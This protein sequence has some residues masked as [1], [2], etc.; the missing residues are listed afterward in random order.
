MVSTVFRENYMGPGGLPASTP[1]GGAVRVDASGSFSLQR[2]SFFG[3]YIWGPVALLGPAT[4]G[5]GAVAVSSTNTTI[6]SCTFVGN[7]VSTGGGGEG[8]ALHVGS[9]ASAM[10]VTVIGSAFHRNNALGTRTGAGGAIFVGAERVALTMTSCVVATSYV[11][12][13]QATTGTGLVWGRGAGLAVSNGRQL[14]LTN[15][16]FASNSI[17]VRSVKAGSGQGHGAGIWVGAVQRGAAFTS[18]TIR[19]N[20][21]SAYPSN[22]SLASPQLSWVGGAG[23]AWVAPSSLRISRTLITENW[24]GANPAAPFWTNFRGTFLATGSE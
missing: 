5:G 1:L 6:G 7:S 3:N 2:S 21:V 24:A 14:T 13:D 9:A 18:C 8:G 22:V 23:L 19:F 4:L 12:I 17:E 11:G 16:T 20:G 10:V 15:V